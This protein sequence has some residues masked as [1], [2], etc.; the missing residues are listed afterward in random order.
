M[1]YAKEV[2]IVIRMISGLRGRAIVGMI[3]TLHC[4][5]NKYRWFNGDD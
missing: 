5:L 4:L 3:R 1:V 2:G